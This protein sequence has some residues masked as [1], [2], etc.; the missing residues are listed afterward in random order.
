M[1]ILGTVTGVGMVFGWESHHHHVDHLIAMLSGHRCTNVPKSIASCDH[2]VEQIPPVSS[3]R[4]KFATAPL[5]GRLAY[6]MFRILASENLT[7]VILNCTFSTDQPTLYKTTGTYTIEGRFVEFKV[8]NSQYCLIEGSGN[9][10][11]LHYSVGGRAGPAEGDPAMI[12]VP[13][14]KEY[15]N[16]YSLPS[17][18]HNDNSFTF[19]HYMNIFIPAQYCQPD[20]VFLDNQLLSSYRL[21]FS[22]L[23]QDGVPK[24]Y[25]A[26]VNLTEG[27]HTLHHADA[28]A[29]L[30]VIMY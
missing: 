18:Q 5:K 6:D 24:V 11:V 9:I 13:A 7:T 30:E 16:G 4:Q 21:N 3:W 2:L 15:C 17:I 1:Y 28:E 23:T 8:S 20:Q 10:L 19:T 26:Q 25:A 12:I 27:V 29:T 22:A 14:V